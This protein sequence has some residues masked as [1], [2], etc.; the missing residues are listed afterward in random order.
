MFVLQEQCSFRVGTVVVMS[1]GRTRDDAG[2]QPGSRSF[3]LG[4]NVTVTVPEAV[5]EQ[6]TTAFAE[7]F[8]R[9]GKGAKAARTSPERL[10][11]DRI[12]EVAIDQMRE[13]GYDAVTMRSIAKELGTGPA[14]L[15]AHV[16][17]RQ[18]LDALV[19]DRVAGTW[20]LPEVDPERWEDQLRA[21]MHDMLALYRAHPGVARASMGVI[22]MQPGA[23][24][25]MERLVEMMLAGGVTPQLAA[26]F[27][28]LM[29]LYVGGIAVEED[30]WRQREEDGGMVHDHAAHEDQVRDF[31]ASL[32]A[33]HF[34]NLVALAP[35]MA[36]G[37]GDDRFTF[38]VDLLIAGLKSLSSSDPD[39][40]TDRRVRPPAR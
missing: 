39:F 10:S 22:P 33:D 6:V 3:Q 36:S 14:S 4:K 9:G 19:L 15:Y 5:A 27:C 12:V 24:V 35:D 11:A 20:E 2:K 29:A 8:G 38:G 1:A 28:D 18:E 40:G 23:L 17:N 7:T 34:P 21:A 26:W 25:G 16:A 37:D 30:I 31:M 13:R 32:P